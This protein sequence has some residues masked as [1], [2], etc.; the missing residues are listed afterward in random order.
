ML[1]QSRQPTFGYCYWASVAHGR[2]ITGPCVTF[3][4]ANH[5]GSKKTKVRHSIG[6]L[7]CRKQVLAAELGPE[8]AAK[9]IPELSFGQR[10]DIGN[11]SS[12]TILPM[13]GQG[14]AGFNFALGNIFKIKLHI[15]GWPFSSTKIIPGH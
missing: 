15:S 7:L 1:A 4:T 11:R 10:P 5:S 3:T 13:L 6:P 8:L 2:H 12:A 9:C 14:W